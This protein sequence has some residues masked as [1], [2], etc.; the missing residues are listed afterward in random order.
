MSIVSLSTMKEVSRT[1][2]VDGPVWPF[3]DTQR[4][5]V[6]VGGSALG[7]VGVYNSTTGQQE[8]IINTGGRPHAFGLHGNILIAS[9]T[10][11]NTETHMSAI[12]A[13]TRQVISTQVSPALPHGIVYDSVKN[14][15]YMVGVKTGAVAI[16]NADTGA[17][18]STFDDLSGTGNSNMLAFSTKDR[19][20]FI[21]D[22]QISSDITVVNVDTR[23]KVGTI[24]LSGNGSTVWGMQVDDS[25]GL[26]YAAMPDADAIGVADVNNLRALGMIKVDSCPYAVRLDTQ[27]GLG[28]STGQVHA[29]LSVFKLADVKKALGR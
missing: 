20:L 6:Y 14:V 24:N 27:L 1:P 5:V 2:V 11:D 9:N 29:N 23:Q 28:V 18:E 8:A 17:I 12:N 26:L 22:S 21:A 3:V 10:G 7:Q 16:I 25:T 19:K 13:N 15:F 4:G